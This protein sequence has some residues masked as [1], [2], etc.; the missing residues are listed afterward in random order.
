MASNQRVVNVRVAPE[1]PVIAKHDRLA[2][3]VEIDVTVNPDGKVTGVK[4]ISGN[5]LLAK[6]AKDALQKWRFAPSPVA[7]SENVKVN[8]SYHND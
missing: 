8:F 2:G 1:Y 3:P 5:P 4:T 6:A 7:S